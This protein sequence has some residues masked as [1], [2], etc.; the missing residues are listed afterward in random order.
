MGRT[1]S[2][3]VLLAHLTRGELPVCEEAE[4]KHRKTEIKIVREGTGGVGGGGGRGRF[5][6]A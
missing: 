3:S 4:L 2:P 5:E 1:V 6:V